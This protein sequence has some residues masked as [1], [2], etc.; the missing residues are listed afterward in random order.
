MGTIDTPTA[1]HVATWMQLRGDY[2]RMVMRHEPDPD[3]AAL[4][5]VDLQNRAV[6]PEFGAVAHLLEQK[7]A[8]IAQYY[9]PRLRKQVMPNTQRLLSY[10]RQHKLRVIHLTI[11]PALPDGSD[12]ISPIGRGYADIEA[13]TGIRGLHPIGTPAHAIIDELQPLPNELVINKTTASAFNS[14]SIEATLRTMGIRFLVIAGVATN[15]CVELTAR[16]AADRG[17]LVTIVDDACATWSQMMHDHCL[18]NFHLFLGEVK[19]TD[20][21]LSDLH[22]GSPPP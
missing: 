19:T 10:F 5:L 14:T 17:F 20:E 8:S 6:N 11:G 22:V 18:L 7:Y 16:D 2:P 21:V 4:V 9:F 15:A 13:T 3:A 12:M 1:T